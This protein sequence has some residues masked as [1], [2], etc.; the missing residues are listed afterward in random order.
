M[1]L[2]LV[3]ARSMCHLR[4]GTSTP[5]PIVRIAPYSNVRDGRLAFQSSYKRL[6]Q[7]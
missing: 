1:G 6:L 7:R 4:N 3:P 5:A 2:A